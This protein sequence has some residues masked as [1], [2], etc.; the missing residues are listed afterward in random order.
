MSC[1]SDFVVALRSNNKTNQWLLF[2]IFFSRRKK[3]VLGLQPLLDIVKFRKIH[4]DRILIGFD[5]K[6]IG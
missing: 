2:F 5:R 6:I 4:V 3:N 1:L